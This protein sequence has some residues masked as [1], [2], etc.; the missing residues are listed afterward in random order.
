M[1]NT[2]CTMIASSRRSV[3]VSERSR[4]HSIP[5]AESKLNTVIAKH[6]ANHQSLAKS[7]HSDVCVI[8]LDDI[9]EMNYI[10][11]LPCGHAY[12]SDCIYKW[13]C[14]RQVCPMCGSPI[15]FD[16]KGE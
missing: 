15:K 2:F 3:D 11:D 16:L 6:I 4:T 13:L 12:H 10:L 14:K 1:G 9:L 5:K 7:T 8:C